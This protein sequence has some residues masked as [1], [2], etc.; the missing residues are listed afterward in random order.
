L[1]RPIATLHRHFQVTH[2]LFL[3]HQLIPSCPCAIEG[4]QEPLELLAVPAELLAVFR[5]LVASFFFR[6]TLGFS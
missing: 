4:V 1:A 3:Q 2:Q 5:L 6:F